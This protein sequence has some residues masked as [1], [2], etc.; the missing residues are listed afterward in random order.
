MAFTLGQLHAIEAALASGS[1]KVSYDGKTVEYRSTDDL[2]KTRNL[3]RGDLI[4]TG[5]LASVASSNRGPGSLAV[6]S[7]D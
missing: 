2:I 6:F 7:R 5:V 4:A 1:L 3:I